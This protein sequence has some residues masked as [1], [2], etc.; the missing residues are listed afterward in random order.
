[1][2]DIT[3]TQGAGKTIKFSPQ[4]NYRIT[5]THVGE[6]STG[7]VLLAEN[8][9]TGVYS[10]V[11]IVNK[12]QKW[13]REDALK[14]IEV[15]KKLK[16]ENIIQLHGIE[17]DDDYIFLFTEF[18]NEGDIYTFMQRNG[19]FSEESAF[20]LFRQMVFALEHCHKNNIS[21]HDFKLENIV[22]NKNGDL[23]LIDFAFAVEFF[24]SSSGNY[25]NKYNGSPAYSAPEILFRKPHNES[26]DLYGLGTC[27][28]FMLCMCFPFCD[29]DSTTFEELCMNV[30]AFDLEFPHGLSA[31]VRDLIKK[32]VTKQNRLSFEQI[33]QHPWWKKHE[34]LAL[35]V[36]GDQPLQSTNPTEPC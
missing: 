36:A 30:R 9:H 15:L 4:R 27:L 18:L 10:A 19:R 29:D 31:E 8:V 3:T 7:K 21:H 17:E 13:M 33:V 11:K 1:M 35:S 34:S 14:E 26:V 6:G 5:S 28:Y 22:I 12:Q 25:I 2:A 16:H 23:R 24:K 20:K 32:L